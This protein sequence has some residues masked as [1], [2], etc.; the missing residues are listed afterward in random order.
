MPQVGRRARKL[1]EDDDARTFA[2]GLLAVHLSAGGTG[3]LRRLDRED[4]R[5]SD[6]KRVLV[7]VLTSADARRGPR[8]AV[9]GEN[10]GRQC[11]EQWLGGKV[12]VELGDGRKT[13]AEDRVALA[14]HQTEFLREL[15]P[16]LEHPADRRAVLFHAFG[17]GR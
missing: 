6:G 11:G 3:T 17:L 16:L 2:L 12:Q 9:G 1:L 14:G 13:L 8:R 10:R 7:A 4:H 5:R 15:A